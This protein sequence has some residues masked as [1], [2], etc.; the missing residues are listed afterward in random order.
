M[1]VLHVLSM[2]IQTQ[3]QLLDTRQADMH[4]EHP[5]HVQQMT[6]R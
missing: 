3:L 5:A 1:N 2:A 6:E 4:V